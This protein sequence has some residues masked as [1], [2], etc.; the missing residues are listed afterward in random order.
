MSLLSQRP[1]SGSVIYIVLNVAL[2]LSIQACFVLS[3]IHDYVI[4]DLCAFKSEP[5]A[6]R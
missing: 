6:G 1:C 3:D 5:P 4:D 2:A